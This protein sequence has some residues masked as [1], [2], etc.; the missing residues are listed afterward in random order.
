[1]SRQAPSVASRLEHADAETPA[2]ESRVVGDA[3]V[4]FLGL[5]AAQAEALGFAP[6]GLK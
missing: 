5:S 4:V 3:F 6:A 2:L 1:M